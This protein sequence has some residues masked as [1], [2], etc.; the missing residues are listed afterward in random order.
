MAP[1]GVLDLNP[2]RVTLSNV[3][4]KFP[5]KP[6]VV[7]LKRRI[8][9]MVG[10][11]C[12]TR[13]LGGE[14]LPS[15]SV[16]AVKSDKVDVVPSVISPIKVIVAVV[17]SDFSSAAVIAAETLAYLPVPVPVPGTSAVKSRSVAPEVPEEHN[18][19]PIR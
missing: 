18:N 11:P 3:R 19:K 1:P 12:K 16:M 6:P 10:S 15:L 8:S 17:V 5:V 13:A 14:T 4:C 7:L 2:L 9:L